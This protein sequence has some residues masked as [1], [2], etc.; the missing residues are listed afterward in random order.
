MGARC[1]VTRLLRPSGG[2]HS[3]A[4][5]RALHAAQ[6]SSV[7][8]GSR[9]QPSSPESC[10]E[11]PRLGLFTANQ[12]TGCQRR[13]CRFDPW[14]REIPWRRAFQPP[15]VFLPGESRAQRSLGGYSP[16]GRKESDTTECAW[17]QTR[18]ASPGRSLPSV[19]GPNAGGFC[20]VEASAPGLPVEVLYL[21]GSGGCPSL[22]LGQAWELGGGWEEEA[23]GWAWNPSSPPPQPPAARSPS[24]QQLPRCP[25]TRAPVSVAFLGK[26]QAFLSLSP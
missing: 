21:G 5:C 13:R 25:R 16:W 2:S 18:R 15:P 12:E 14:V 10:S 22:G 7:F 6:I 17:A 8:V 26:Q 1:P 20:S 3:P 11:G 4:L 19:N 23:D 24:G 9:T